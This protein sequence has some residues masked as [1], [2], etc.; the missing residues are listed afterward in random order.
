MFEDL[1]PGIVHIT[2][3]SEPGANCKPQDECIPYLGGGDVDLVVIVDVLVEFLIE[4]IAA[5]ES[6][7]DQAKDRRNRQLKP[8]RS[9]VW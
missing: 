2:A 3:H 1:F 7:A 5:F 4:L 6:E 9:E 8:L